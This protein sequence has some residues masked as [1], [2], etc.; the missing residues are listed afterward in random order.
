MTDISAVFNQPGAAFVHLPDGI[1]FPP[2]EKEWQNK[3]HTFAQAQAHKGNVGIL[4]G[5]GFIGLDQDDPSAFSGLELPITTTWETR[6]GRFGLW[7]KTADVAEALESI[8][9][10]PSQAQLKLFQDGKPVGEVKLQ[11]TYQVIPNSW[12]NL[13]DGTRA[14]YKLLSSEPPTEISMVKLLADLQSIGVTFSS[15][16]EANAAKLEEM[17][18]KARQSRVE[19]DEARARRYAEA[20]LR[21]EVLTLAGTPDGNRNHQLNRSAF[22]MGQFIAAKVLSEDEVISE[23]SRAAANT[24]L[25]SDEIRTTI[26]SGLQ[27][28]R[29]HPREIPEKPNGTGPKEGAARKILDCIDSEELTEGGN[30]SRLERLFGNEMRYNHTH[31]KWY[32]WEGG[33]WQVDTNGGSMR[34]AAN[35]VGALYLAAADADGKDE[36][37]AIVNFA[38][39]TDTRKGLSNMLAIAANRLQ[40]A[41]TADKLDSNAWLLGAGN[42][43]FDL[44]TG[45]TR[46]PHRE[47]LITKAIGVRHDRAAKCPRWIKFI[48][49]IFS[50]DKE[51]IAYIKRAFG[52][53][54]TGSMDEQVF[55]FCHGD[56]SNGKSK[57]LAILRALL[58]EYAKQA[59]FSTFMVQRNEKVRNDLAALAGARVITAIEAEEGGRLSM[60]VIK[61]WTGGD[62]ITARFLFGENFTFQPTGKIWLAANNKPAI[63]ERNHAAWR[64]VQLIPFNVTIAEKDQDKQIEAKLLKEL[65]G[66]LNWALDGLADY[67]KVGLNTPNAVRVATDQ[68]RK[69]NDNLEMF[70][71]ECCDVGKLKVCDNQDLYFAYLNFCSMSGTHALSQTKFSPELNT[72]P[73]IKSTRNKHG[74]FW[75][76]IELKKDW[77]RVEENPISHTCAA[78]GVGL[79]QNAQSISNS[80]L[81]EDFAQM[82]PNSAPHSESNPTPSLWMGDKTAPERERF[83]AGHQKHA[84]KNKRTCHV[85]GYVSDHDL[86]PDH[87]NRE[88][89]D[90]YICT[91]CLISHQAKSTAKPQAEDT[92]PSGSQ[93]ELESEEAQA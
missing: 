57:F 77:C 88:Y 64:R 56:G 14:D 84:A 26:V 93:T 81:R 66:I 79:K 89:M 21:D 82:T 65:P 33:R 67:M 48:A 54:L 53:C 11:R 50:E 13:E 39:E 2:V 91:S 68:Y 31:K 43:T 76:G 10:K 46:E 73:G 51:L 15:K 60:Q 92:A 90:C 58:G 30:A 9:K 59:D 85:C 47:D 22:A 35:V 72:R 24:G 61:S 16:L 37:K 8:G 63:S 75:N 28:G 80:A 27:A 18:K 5:S 78:K 69:E 36:R 29:H 1:K 19:S 23:L 62:P 70:V 49:Q 7:F 4:A 71:S 86:I 25:D 83:K 74:V 44:K 87:S 20:A 12:K 17:G 38:K 6:P 42:V 52:Y 41:I 40:F 55:F 34:L 32:L 3:P 45:N